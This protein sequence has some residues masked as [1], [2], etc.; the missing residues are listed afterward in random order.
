VK[1][2][3]DKTY[4]SVSDLKWNEHQQK[5]GKCLKIKDLDLGVRLFKVIVSAD[6][7]DYVLTNNLRTHTVE[8]IAK[9]QKMR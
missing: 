9:M 5:Y 8:F 3:T 7:T 6:R 1:E 2:S 4:S